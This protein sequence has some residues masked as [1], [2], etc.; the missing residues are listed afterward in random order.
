MHTRCT[1]HGC[2]HFAKLG[3]YCLYH[4]RA[5]GLM[6]LPLRRPYTPTAAN[7]T[8]PFVRSSDKAHGSDVAAKPQARYD[9]P[10][11][12]LPRLKSARMCRVAGCSSYARRQGRCSRHGGSITCA[13]EG[14][15]TPAQTGGKCRA[16]GGGS[17]CKMDGCGAFARTQGL[18]GQHR[19]VAQ[20]TL[21]ARSA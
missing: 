6:S 12:S 9:H 2:P 21:A 1:T 11:N 13:A 7:D 14:C 18:C 16:H 15:A 20:Q 10:N 8:F 4:S 3:N 5:F 19:Q 17:L